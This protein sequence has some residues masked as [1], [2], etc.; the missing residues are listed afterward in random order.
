MECGGTTQF[1]SPSPARIKLE[2]GLCQ[3]SGNHGLRAL[4]EVRGPRNSEPRHLLG[5]LFVTYA[6]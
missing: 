3:L 5:Q 1:P 6:V 4:E 2:E